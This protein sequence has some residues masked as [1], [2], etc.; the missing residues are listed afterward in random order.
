[1]IGI[2]A[3]TTVAAV[4][5]MAGLAMLLAGFLMD[6]MEANQKKC[7]RQKREPFI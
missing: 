1:M 6:W 3:V 7:E 2:W 5:V 4:M